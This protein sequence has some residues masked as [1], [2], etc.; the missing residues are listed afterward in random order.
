MK[1]ITIGDI[2]AIL[3]LVAVIVLVILAIP[4]GIDRMEKA[5]CEQLAIFADRYS[6]FYLTEW[7][8]EMCA[9]AEVE[10]NAPVK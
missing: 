3:M 7:Q 2:I 10:V 6:E 9:H 5:E 8:A 1:D 4:K